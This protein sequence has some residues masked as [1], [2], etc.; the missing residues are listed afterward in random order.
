MNRE[1]RRKSLFSRGYGDVRKR[2][3]NAKVRNCFNCRYFYQAKG[4]EEELCQNEEVFKFDMI[5]TDFG[6]CCSRWEMIPR[7][8]VNAK[9]VFKKRFS[10]KGK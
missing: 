1:E 4:D 3:D 8:D 2:V 9:S 5:Y 7:T 6:V 10:K